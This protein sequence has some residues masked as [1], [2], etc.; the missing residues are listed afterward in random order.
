MDNFGCAALTS[1]STIESLTSTSGQYFT[2]GTDTFVNYDNTLGLH[3]GNY[4]YLQGAS[5]GGLWLSDGHDR[6]DNIVL[7][8][9]THEI[10]FYTNNNTT[11]NIALTSASSA[12]SVLISGGARFLNYGDGFVG[13][14]G[15]LGLHSNQ[16]VYMQGG[17]AGGLW[18]S[19]SHDRTDNIV[20]RTPT[21]EINLYT[22][23]SAT[24]SIAVN[25]AGNVGIGTRT[26]RDTFDVETGLNHFAYIGGNAAGHRG[27]KIGPNSNGYAYLQGFAWTDGSARDISLQLDGNNVGIGTVS[28]GQKLDVAGTIRQSNCTTAGTLSTNASGDIICTSDARLKNVLGDYAG[29]LD[30]I[31]RITPQRF[32][33]K[34]TSNNPIETF[35]HAG[36]IAQNVKDV[37]PEAVAMQR[38]GYYSL[39]TTAI[40]AAAVNAIKQLKA[41]NENQAAEIRGL[42]RAQIAESTRMQMQL[43]T[44]QRQVGIQTA[45]K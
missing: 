35:V 31:T 29:G 42:R 24:A 2:N 38:S 39:D 1:G 36:F 15:T 13:Y 27:V 40:L 16:F 18:L 26:P 28:P 25:A 44:L 17:S 20:V 43:I 41:A 8:N 10:D 22:N 12:Q 11:P 19:D 4:L 14:D 5:S 37:I 32:T 9:T 3:S 7:R 30:A 21:H 6:Y 33:Y 23:N 45:R 34:P